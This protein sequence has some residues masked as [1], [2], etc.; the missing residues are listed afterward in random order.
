MIG[1]IIFT[2]PSEDGNITEAN[3]YAP[4]PNGEAR[5]PSSVQR[6]SVQFLSTYPGDPTTP[7]YPSKEGSPRVDP[8]AVVPRIPSIPMSYEDVIPI[9]SALDGF[10]LTGVEVNRTGWVGALNVSY[11]T[12]PAPGTTIN[13]TNLMEDTYT[14]IW[15]SVG[16]IN[17]TI[18]DETIVIGNHRDAWIIG[19][20]ADPR[21]VF[22]LVPMSP[23][24]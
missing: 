19:G 10:G 5:N 4:Y 8:S 16:I 6:G 7:G 11:S 18:A 3:G 22:P 20:A 9:L 15:N 21:Y 2:D 13:M 17:G 14:P 23:M 24:V 12:G 1:V